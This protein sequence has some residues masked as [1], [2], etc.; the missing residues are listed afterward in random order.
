[1]LDYLLIRSERRK[2]LGLQVKQGRIIVRAPKFVDLGFIEG[3]LQKKSAWLQEKMLEQRAA[4]TQHCH[5]T[6]G[7]QLYILGKKHTVSIGQATKS[8]TY[9]VSTHDGSTH[10]GSK[11]VVSNSHLDDLPCLQVN[12]SNRIYAK[13]ADDNDLT[14]SVKKH[15]EAY[16]SVQANEVIL[17]RVTQLIK[18]TSLIPSKIK[19]RQYK[20][21]WGSC[22]SRKE[23]SLNYLLMMTPSWVIDYVIIHELCHL[24]YLNHSLQFWNLVKT[25]CPEYK[26]AKQWL[27]T[28]QKDLYWSAIK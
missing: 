21:R 18:Q 2:T 22:N 14:R 26:E 13:F 16:F 10:D 25:H 27:T 12:I 23:V 5:F 4:I 20:A 28:H 8:E 24:V 11:Y 17:P 9:I 1:M 3:F 15:I 6:S 7:A 19:I